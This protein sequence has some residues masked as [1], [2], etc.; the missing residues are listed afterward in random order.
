MADWKTEGYS[1]SLFRYLVVSAVDALLL[2]GWR[3]DAA[4]C[5]V[6][7]QEFP[8]DQ[9]LRGV[10]ERTIWRWFKAYHDHGLDGLK[11]A[12][13][14]HVEDS[15]VLP[16]KF[17]AYLRAER[18]RDPGA[19]IPELIRRARCQ[20][21]LHPEKEVDRVT[22]WR[23]MR[24]M[25]LPTRIPSIVEANDM[26]RFGFAERMQLVMLDFKH[27][28]AGIQ[29][30]KRAAI[31]M[32]DDATR[33]GLGVVVTTS[34]QV[35]AVLRVLV[36][37]LRQ[38]GFMTILYWD[39][40]SAFRDHD[41][42]EI[43]SQLGITVIRGRAH[44]PPARGK[45]E[46]FNRAVKA[47]IL[48]AL[49]GSAL[50]D[51]DCEALTLLLRHDLEVYNNLPHESL[52]GDTPAQRFFSSTAVPL[53]P[54]PSEAWLIEK[55]TLTDSRKASNDHVIPF[56]GNDYEVPLGF[57]GKRVEFFRR[58]LENDALYVMHEGHLLR[59]HP[60][61]RLANAHSRR[62]KRASSQADDPAQPAPTAS[63]LSFQKQYQTILRPDGGFP[64]PD[65]KKEDP[66]H[67]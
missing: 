50:V 7:G 54:I 25:G 21:A 42:L 39:G 8:C 29:R 58:P 14:A 19:S 51:P 40:G 38:F 28:R 33:C 66:D 9:E 18:V 35:L 20:G 16:E 53:R 47:R 5:A 67:E 23:V 32:L 59:L 10:S 2:Q 17:L 56:K 43:C 34:E 57:G 13:R 62:A 55:F 22:V 24:R 65:S 26:R 41:V 60:V 52:D 63:M 64:D 36:E 46:R 44:Y 1:E 45:I 31:Y 48:R 27:F 3:H 30:L 61:D 49:A 15:V 6:S 11:R 37:T 4:V 12:E